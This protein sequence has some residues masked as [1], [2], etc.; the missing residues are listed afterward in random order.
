MHILIIILTSRFNQYIH[1]QGINLTKGRKFVNQLNGYYLKRIDFS[2]AYTRHTLSF[3]FMSVLIE[4]IT[5]K[6][7]TSKPK[8][9]QDLAGY[10][11]SHKCLWVLARI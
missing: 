4:I 2:D 6:S 10:N 5:A 11:N 3:G 8:H 9:L 1:T 7:L